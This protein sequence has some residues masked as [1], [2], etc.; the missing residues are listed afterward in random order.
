MVMCVVIKKDDVCVSREDLVM[1]VGANIRV[2]KT[3]YSVLNSI[4]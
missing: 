4:M 2:T 3:I 1:I